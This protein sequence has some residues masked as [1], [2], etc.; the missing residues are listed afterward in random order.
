MAL[1]VPLTLGTIIVGGALLG[2]LFLGEPIT[3]RTFA[4]M[5][6]L[7]LAITILSLG[8]GD[9]HRSVVGVLPNGE[10][11]A[12]DWYL[13]AAGVGAATLSGVGR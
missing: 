6:A 9:A 12:W 1:S 10:R 11:P 7:I 8:A 5:A 3:A 4:S 13:L 2:R